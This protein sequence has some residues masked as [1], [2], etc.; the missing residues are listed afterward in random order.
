MMHACI[1][2]Q[3]LVSLNSRV[4]WGVSFLA[5]FTYFACCSC[6]WMNFITNFIGSRL[7]GRY[8]YDALR[9]GSKFGIPTF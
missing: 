8:I 3:S 4:I 9:N 6:S 7:Q 2:G 5:Q 1:K